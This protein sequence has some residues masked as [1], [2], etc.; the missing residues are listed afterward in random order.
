VLSAAALKDAVSLLEDPALVEEAGAAA[1]S[2]G[3]SLKGGD[4][5]AAIEAMAKVSEK[6]KVKATVEE[7]KRISAGK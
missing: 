5:T 6:C 1:V 2:I 4:K 3:K 7:A